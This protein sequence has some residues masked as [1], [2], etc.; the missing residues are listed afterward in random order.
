MQVLEPQCPP[1]APPV[2]VGSGPTRVR[3][4]IA[5]G[6]GL[7]LALG[8]CLCAYARLGASK[9]VPTWQW[10]LSHGLD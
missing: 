1:R 3:K 9:A 2:Q 4:R 7:R 5:L 10:A 8:L 6:P